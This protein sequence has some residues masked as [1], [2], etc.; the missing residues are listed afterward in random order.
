MKRY[1]RILVL[2]GVLA[3]FS[4]ATFAL[5]QYEQKQEEIKNSD[6]IILEIPAD[7][8]TAL[9]WEYSGGGALAFTKTEDGWQY[10]EDDAFPVSEKKVA[11]I[12]A[13][14]E[15]Y[16]VAFLIENV[17]DY[18][19]Y[20]LDDPECTM[21]LT[22]DTQTYELK[23]GNFSKMDE[24]RY[25]DIGDG[26]VYL[27]SE[28][29]MDYVDAALSSMI[30][31][32][33]T[34]GFE[35]V[36]DITFAGSENYTIVRE[37]ESTHTY[38]RDDDI[39]FTQHDG[40]TVPLDSAK[41]LQYLNTITALDLQNY[42]TY[43]ATEEEL[44]SYGLD[45]PLLSITVNY[46]YTD[47]EDQT[48]ADS[49]VVN[50]S[51][52]PQERAASDEAV[53]AGNAATSVTKYVRIGDSSIVYTLSDV[54]F[55]LLKAASYDDLRHKEVFWADFETVTQMDIQ[56]E[57]QTHTLLYRSINEEEDT[58]EFG[59]FY[60]EEEVSIDEIE[61]SLCNLTADSF[62]SEQPDNVEELAL[63]LYLDNEF[64]PTV[65]IQLYRYDGS[66]CLAVVDGK[67]V[68]LVSRS[69]AMELVESIQKIVLNG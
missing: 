9:S 22:T 63:T 42:V 55:G 64:F 19:Q 24:Q 68:C 25:I 40:Q 36:T 4:I 51:E 48:V 17:E 53:A 15:N 61:A 32:D 49:C 59:W 11:Q 47:E 45:N 57:G 2:L 37:D 6:A 43:D 35:Y 62:T 7:S 23:M 20:G 28:D 56:L 67:S 10:D 13:H 58:S 54:N 12:L 34:P 44:Q 69:T 18:S 66:L 33:D 1:K 14:F 26:N 39:Y 60:G 29:P 21:H 41:M 5:T 50:I 27:V 31:H 52:N 8:V 46:T 65:K 30:A 38:N 16:G 3:V